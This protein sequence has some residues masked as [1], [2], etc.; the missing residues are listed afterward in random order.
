MYA[1]I[2]I[3]YIIMIIIFVANM[4][5]A[6]EEASTGLSFYF[7]PNK[8]SFKAVVAAVIHSLYIQG[9]TYG[10]I[11]LYGSQSVFRSRIDITALRICA[12]TTLTSLFTGTVVFLRMRMRDRDYSQQTHHKFVYNTDT[13]V[14]M[15]LPYIFY[16]LRRQNSV[17]TL[18][19]YESP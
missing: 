6:A 5:R 18:R 3:A 4:L 12:I 14:G 7:I 16:L 1:L 15:F 11:L 2:P 10:I 9:A 8:I 17:K 13:V 19:R